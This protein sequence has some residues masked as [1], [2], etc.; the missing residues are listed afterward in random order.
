MN[1]DFPYGHGFFILFAIV[2]FVRW[3][4]GDFNEKI[5][6]TQPENKKQIEYYVNNV[7]IDEP[8]QIYYLKTL[9][10]L[11]NNNVDDKVI[12]RAAANKITAIKMAE[13]EVIPYC[14]QDILAAKCFLLD[15]WSYRVNLN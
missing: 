6:A 11:E 15:N 9:D 10:L 1:N 13:A 7:M 4:K 8:H 12:K 3:L 5:S 14:T 2:Q